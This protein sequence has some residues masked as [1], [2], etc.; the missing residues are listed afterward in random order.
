M[1]IFCH[2]TYA[3][4]CINFPYKASNHNSKYTG[5]IGNS[6]RFGQFFPDLRSPYLSDIESTDDSA[7]ILDEC[8]IYLMGPRRPLGVSALRR[9]ILSNL[10]V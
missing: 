9:A 3:T 1:P 8:S 4:A 2:I 5:P 10:G 6:I 7:R